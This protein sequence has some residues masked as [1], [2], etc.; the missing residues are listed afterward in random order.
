MNLFKRGKRVNISWE[1][2]ITTWTYPKSRLINFKGKRSNILYKKWR[3]DISL[4]ESKLLIL[5]LVTV[6]K[7]SVR[8][9]DGSVYVKYRFK[10][11]NKK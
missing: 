2:G 3:Q 6:Y 7:Y 5:G 11:I 10:V 4:W 1:N 9:N 8:K